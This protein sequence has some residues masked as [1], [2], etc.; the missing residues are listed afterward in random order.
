MNEKGKE[1][2]KENK[3]RE[4]ETEED[5]T[6]EAAE[7]ERGE[8]LVS[9]RKESLEEEGRLGGEEGAGSSEGHRKAAH[10]I[11]MLQI[12]ENTQPRGFILLSG[13]ASS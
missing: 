6:D 9:G 11:D 7:E 1:G 2:L 12:L 10:Y 13:L 5:E 8:R 4:R 3:E